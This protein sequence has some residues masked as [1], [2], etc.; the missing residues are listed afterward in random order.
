MS[1]LKSQETY[2]FNQIRV[3]EKIKVGEKIKAQFENFK[4]L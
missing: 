1:N 3:Y 2:L 4:K